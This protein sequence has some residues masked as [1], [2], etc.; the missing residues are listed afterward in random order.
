MSRRHT[1]RAGRTTRAAPARVAAEAI[2]ASGGAEATRGW[3][4]TRGC[5]DVEAKAGGDGERERRDTDKARSHYGCVPLTRQQLEVCE[6]E[7]LIALGD[8]GRLSSHCEMN[9]EGSNHTRRRLEA[10][11]IAPGDDRLLSHQEM[12]GGSYRAKT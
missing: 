1:G 8:N 3:E 4:T 6:Q 7:A 9:G 11:P 5:R 2:I 10:A 12:T